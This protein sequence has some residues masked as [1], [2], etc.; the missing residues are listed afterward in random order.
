MSTPGDIASNLAADL[1]VL[2][3]SHNFPPA[4]GAESLLVRNNAVYLHQRGWR[5]GVLTAPKKIS[6]AKEDGGLMRD[7]PDGIDVIRTSTS[8]SLTKPGQGK[9]TR[10]VFGRIETRLLP[11]SSL[12]WKKEAVALGRRWLD[13]GG[14]AI[15]YSRAPRHVSSLT[16]RELKKQTGLPWVAHLSDPWFD[17][18]YEGF[19]HRA[20]IRSLE[21]SVISEADAVVFVN[22]PQSDKVMAKYPDEW[23]RKVLVIPHGFA[24]FQNADASA[25][26]EGARPLRL[27]HTGAFYPVYRTPDSLFE[28]IAELNKRLPLEGRLSLECV[29]DE[30]TCFQPLV[31]KLGLEKIVTL[32][33]SVPYDE[34]Q[35]IIA[36]ADL[37]VVVDVTHGLRGVFLPTKL[38]EY[39]AFQKP[40]LGISPPGSAVAQTLEGCGLQNANQDDANAI[41]SALEQQLRLWEAGSFDLAPATK[42][43][44]AG[45]HINQVNKP[46]NSLFKALL[47]GVA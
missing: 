34:C 46:L 25:N 15:L 31:N 1:R 39:F 18:S 43:R 24:S 37:L 17:F 40:V 26:R 8:G 19:F 33:D 2:L 16:A 12:F 13:K 28:G 3:V 41:A 22:Q 9:L 32:K 20:W 5:V 42:A 27:L 10:V 6:R 36:A 4:Q 11:C 7:V 45:Y 23:R 30:T 21:R 44:M 38:I 47:Q 29:G 14:R 35:R